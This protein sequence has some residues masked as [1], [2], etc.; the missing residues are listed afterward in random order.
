MKTISRSRPRV[1]SETPDVAPEQQRVELARSSPR[2]LEVGPGDE[3]REDRGR[4]EEEADEDGQRSEV[5]KRP[6]KVVPSGALRRG[7]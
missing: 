6:P 4:A 2:P 3:D 5:S 1:I 7:E